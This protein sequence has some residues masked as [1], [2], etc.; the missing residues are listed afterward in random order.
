MQ[1][2]FVSQFCKTLK[3]KI[4]K[5]IFLAAGILLTA[6]TA[7]FAQNNISNDAQEAKMNGT[8]TRKEMREERRAENRNEVSSSTIN[9][10]ALD[11]PGV[12]NVQFAKTKNFDEVTFMSG[13]K[14]MTAYYD[15]KNSLIGTTEEKSF[16]DLPAKA[17]KAI[18]KEY[19]GYTISEVFKFD[20]NEDNGSEMLLYGLP[21]NNAENYFAEL[22]K[23]KKAIVVQVDQA[24]EVSYFINIK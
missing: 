8:E 14:R 6:A 21:F 24:G 13:N 18:H 23:G 11:F 16:A 2:I 22:K 7:T 20:D 1:N 3:T 10:F 9:Q 4:M 12:T 5:K 17:Q 19:A 15:Y